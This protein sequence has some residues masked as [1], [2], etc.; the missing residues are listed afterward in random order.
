MVDSIGFND[1][2]WLDRVGRPHSE[3]LHVVERF[4][5]VSHDSL[6]LDVTFDDP[7]AYTKM[8]TGH[9]M[10]ALSTT[11]FEDRSCSMSEYEHFRQTVID[12]V[13]AP[14]K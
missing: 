13:V 12:P 5:R 6:Q 8:F 3:E 4:R 9:R 14:S 11:P 10:F 1:K 2:T 7:K